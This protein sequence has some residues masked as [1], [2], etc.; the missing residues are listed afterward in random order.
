VDRTFLMIKPSAVAAGHVGGIIAAVEDAGF[1]IVGLTAKTMTT[2][3]ARSFYAVHEGRD[4]YEPLIVYMTSGMTIG[5]L[6]E[7]DDAVALLRRTVGVTDPEEA[8]EGTIRARFGETL[9]RNAVHASDSPESVEHEAS[10]YFSD[11]K[12]AVREDE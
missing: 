2:E 5:L 12:R 7:A 3:E 1:T 10:V 9:R 4:F 6:L 8:A 11:C